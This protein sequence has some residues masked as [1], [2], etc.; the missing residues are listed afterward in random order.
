MYVPLQVQSALSAVHMCDKKSEASLNLSLNHC[1]LEVNKL[2]LINSKSEN[3][4]KSSNLTPGE[5]LGS[6]HGPGPCPARNLS[7][8]PWSSPS[9]PCGLCGALCPH[10]S[11]WRTLLWW[12]WAHP[13]R[14][15]HCPSACPS[16][17]WEGWK[18][19]AT[20]WLCT[21]KGL[22]RGIHSGSLHLGH[23]SSEN[24]CPLYR[25]RKDLQNERY[26]TAHGL[27]ICYTHRLRFQSHVHTVDRED[28]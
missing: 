8:S 25:L 23:F 14:A 15:L 13:D 5:V 11:A 20:A 9:Q 17:S 1:P 2:I 7:S 6:A 16:L 19:S 28:R 4:G 18:G 22:L 10:G 26:S 3:L 27:S 21:R 24:I 12:C